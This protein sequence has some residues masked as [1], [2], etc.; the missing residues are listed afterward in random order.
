MTQMLPS[1]A[2]MVVAIEAT[3]TDYER[4]LALLVLS[5]PDMAM[6]RHPLA[7]RVRSAGKSPAVL[8]AKRA[9]SL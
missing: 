2:V 8:S 3:F 5:L 7:A 1:G 4:N 9:M 6:R